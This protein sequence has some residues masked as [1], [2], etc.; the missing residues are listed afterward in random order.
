[1]AI[2]IAI[3]N[4]KG[5]VYKTSS[6]LILADVFQREGKKTLL[7]D[8]DS[9]I[10]ATILYGG[11]T[12]D[13]T[14]ADVLFSGEDVKKCIQHTEKGD[15][16]ASDTALKDAESSIQGSAYQKPFKLRNSL[17]SIENDYDYIIVDTCPGSSLLLDSV[18]MYV[19]YVLI[20]VTLDKLTVSSTQEFCG[21][22]KEYEEFNPNL[23]VLGLFITQYQENN[24]TRD[25]EENILPDIAKEYNTE[26]LNTKIHVSVKVKE[27]QV[28]DLSLFDYMN[29]DSDNAP[30]AVTDYWSFAE[31]ILAKF[32]K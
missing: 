5:G 21:R 11:D 24:L 4:L 18:L 10:S 19:D 16:L 15:L 1:M 23:K 20:P 9:Q 31:E 6:S 2:K 22:L 27:A 14:M 12:N 28:L 29:K 8:T 3:A 17:K 13:Y 32:E 25:L 30:K 7:V 26:I